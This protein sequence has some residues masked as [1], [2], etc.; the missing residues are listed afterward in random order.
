MSGSDIVAYK[1]SGLS[2]FESSFVYSQYMHRYSSHGRARH[3]HCSW[4]YPD[5]Y[6]IRMVL[7]TCWNEAAAKLA[8]QCPAGV[9]PQLAALR[10]LTLVADASDLQNQQARLKQGPVVELR[11]NSLSNAGQR[12]SGEGVTVRKTEG[13]SSG[14]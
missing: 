1:A 6:D 5:R 10:I 14:G 8:L 3:R 2:L 7:R 13:G 12:H 11:L 9:R 4:P